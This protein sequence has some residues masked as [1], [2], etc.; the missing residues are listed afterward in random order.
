MPDDGDRVS[1][2]IRCKDEERF[3]GFCIQ[4]LL[5]V[6]N[7]PE[8]IVVNDHSAD[9]SL[10]IVRMF[11]HH[12]DIRILDI[13]KYS[14]GR[15]VNQAIEHCSCDTVLV[16]SA[17]CVLDKFDYEIICKH[18]E[19]Y[20]AVFG[21]QVPVYRGR[22]ITP[23]YVWS[24]FGDESVENMMSSIENRHFLHNGLA[25]YRRSILEEMPFDEELY[26]KEDRYWAK[27]VVSLG[28]SYLYDLSLLCTHHWTS[29][30]ATWK[31]IG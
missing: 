28:H 24:H 3:I 14:P 13:D 7:A 2:V 19:T 9:D 17:H 1:V 29:N 10:D 26:G 6:L 18:L 16:I 5:D 30:G 25:V 20:V 15:A 12:A 4:S 27:K 23:R 8:I 21:K 11:D 31:G 22:R